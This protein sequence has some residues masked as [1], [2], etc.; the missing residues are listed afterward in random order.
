MSAGPARRS[1]TPRSIANAA[2]GKRA[3]TTHPY[4]VLLDAMAEGAVLLKADGAIL[5]ANRGF[6]S[7]TGSS[8]EILR[9]SLIQRIASP[10]DRAAL[11]AFLREGHLD[12]TARE[13][14]LMPAT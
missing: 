6:A 4:F 8:L 13:F 3:T 2:A 14:Y 5:F 7:M 11:E 12:R 9:G 10:A 1:K